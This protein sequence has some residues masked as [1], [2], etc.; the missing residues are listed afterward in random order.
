MAQKDLEGNDKEVKKEIVKKQTVKYTADVF[1]I[2]VSESG[3]DQLDKI[4]EEADMI[5]K[6]RWIIKNVKVKNVD[7]LRNGEEGQQFQGDLEKLLKAL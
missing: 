5:A 1:M 6:R 4:N 7:L 2:S 3:Q